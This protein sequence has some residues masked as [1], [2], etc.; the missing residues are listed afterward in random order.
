MGVLGGIA[1]GVVDA[2]RRGA[3]ASGQDI[4]GA[5]RVSAGEAGSADGSVHSIRAKDAIR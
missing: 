1:A 4:S 2:S 5:D 3:T